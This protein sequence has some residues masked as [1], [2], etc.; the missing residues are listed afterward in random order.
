MKN[1][2]LVAM[3]SAVL[4]TGGGPMTVSDRGR[5]KRE[6]SPDNVVECKLAAEAKRE[7]KAAKRLAQR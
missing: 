4:A 1:S 5:A 2:T 7:R 3:L 6:R